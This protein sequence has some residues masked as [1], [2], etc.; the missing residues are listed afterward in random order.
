MLLNENN[1]HTVET[2]DRF[3]SINPNFNI[4]GKDN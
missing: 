1:Y 4:D 3:K 2:G